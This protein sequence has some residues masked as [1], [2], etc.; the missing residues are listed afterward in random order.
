MSLRPQL[1][2]DKQL[3]VYMRGIKGEQ[4]E[5]HPTIQE[6]KLLRSWPNVL[7]DIPK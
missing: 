2:E 7:P 1:Q 3:L 5:N 4:N 6:E